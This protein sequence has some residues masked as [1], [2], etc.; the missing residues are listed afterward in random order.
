MQKM[1]QM[2][3]YKVLIFVMVYRCSGKPSGGPCVLGG[4]QYNVGETWHP[5]EFSSTANSCVHCTCLEGGQ[6]NCTGV[7]CP[8]P[9]CEVPRFIH[10][11]CCP[12]CDEFDNITP[13]VRGDEAGSPETDMPGCDFH[14]DHYEDGDIFPSNKTAY[15]PKHD[16][17]CVL[18]GCY[19]GEVICHLKTCLP[20]PRCRRVVRVDD[21]CCLQCE[22]ESSIDEY[23]MSIGSDNINHTLDDED[24]LSATGRRK[25]GSTWK[26][27]VGE[28]GEMHC[29]VCSCLEG[30]VD[31]KRL[32]CPDVTTLTCR[33]PRPRQDGCCKECP[34]SDRQRDNRKKKRKKSKKGKK[35]RRCKSGDDSEGKKNCKRRGKKRKTKR[36]KNKKSSTSRSSTGDIFTPGMRLDDVFHKLCIPPNVDRLVYHIKGGNFDSVVFDNPKDQTIEHIRWTIRKGRI[37]DTQRNWVLA[38]EDFR[39]NVTVADIVGGVKKKDI[40]RFMRRFAK[41]EQRCKKRCRRKLIERSVK[42]IKAKTIDLSRSCGV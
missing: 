26:P 5:K 35:K 25:N 7:D 17:Q 21:D 3:V 20:S 36:K 34:E 24:C 33:H 29:I 16:N 31:C 10:G 40:K 6:I 37:H 14:G 4:E 9:E 2:L 41:R 19:R 18:C 27:V 38:P 32:T 42:K 22:E 30:Q 12:T 1:T 11:Q 39:R 15:K 23:F 13:T 28:Y 8:S